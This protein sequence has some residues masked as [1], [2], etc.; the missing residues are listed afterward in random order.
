MGLILLIIFVLLFTI[1]KKVENANSLPDSQKI[2]SEMQAGS[3][4]DHITNCILK[5]GSEAIEKLGV[6]GGFIY[7]FEGGKIPFYNLNSRTDYL[8]YSYGSETYFVAY[9]LNKNGYCPQISYAIPDYPRQNTSFSE[10]PGFYNSNTA[11]AFNHLGSDYDGFFG[12][13]NLTK[14]C[15]SAKDS[16]CERFAKGSVLGLSFQKQIEDYLITKL[17]ICVNFSIFSQKLT[18][19]VVA[20][21]PPSAEVNIHDSEVLFFVNY[22]VKVTFEN[23][24]PISVIVDYQA[25]LPARL[26]AVY[27][28]VFNTLSSDAQRIDFNAQTQYVS[29]SFWKSGMKLKQ[30]KAPC[31]D[32]DLP[33]KNNGIIEVADENSI[34][35]G[36]PFALRFAVQDR[37]PAIDF[38]PDQTIDVHGTQ[39]FSIPIDA[40]DPDDYGLHYY[41]MSEGVGSGWKE[42]A[43][44]YG[45]IQ[46]SLQN[47]KK[48]VIPLSNADYGI[49]PIGV[50][51]VDDVSGFFDYQW[52]NLTVE[53]SAATG[54]PTPNCVPD[55]SSDGIVNCYD[56]CNIAANTCQG[57]PANC[58][59]DYLPALPS[60]VDCVQ[61]ILNSSM[62]EP[63]V[64][65]ES[66]SPS[67]SKQDCIN[68]MPD[69]FWVR[70]VSQD[71]DGN[72][73]VNERCVNDYNL[74]NAQDSAYIITQ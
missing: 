64:D 73:L 46:D 71:S 44:D 51:V 65:C 8:N 66:T 68:N 56:W 12:Q 21:A 42:S 23:S 31:S 13:I 32:C 20:E 50:L 48:L 62:P 36:H 3:L 47:E 38:I 59:S 10:L 2:I 5:T 28:F 49:H 45:S 26:G 11:C 25:R 6:N 37:R 24:E 33:E 74:N 1:R 63:H 14:L 7:D 35:N 58:L 15:Y 17:P 19:E 61:G 40:Y 41:F 55:C 70:E 52:F 34:I 29:S 18:A 57:S 27:N 60:C 4:K 39:L 30:I 54:I 67:L 72:S 22:P 53:D 43:P 16:G 69:C 9:G